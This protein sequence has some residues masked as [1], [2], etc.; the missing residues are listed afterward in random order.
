MAQSNILSWV[1][2]L[3]SSLSPPEFAI[4][5]P[6]GLISPKLLTPVTH[7]TLSCSP[8]SQSLYS[9]LTHRSVWLNCM[10]YCVVY[11]CTLWSILSRTPALRCVL[12][13][14]VLFS[15]LFFLP[16]GLFVIIKLRFPAF[17]PRPLFFLSAPRPH[18]DTSYI[19]FFY[20]FHCDCT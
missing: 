18:R 20:F 8:L 5:L 10:C 6:P 13:C 11:C 14:P 17:G 15:F 7:Y 4:S 9:L 2:A 1:Q 12:W 16:V 19:F 3:C